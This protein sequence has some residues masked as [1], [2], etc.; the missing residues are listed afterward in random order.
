MTV[1]QPWLFDLRRMTAV[2][3]GNIEAVRNLTGGLTSDF[4]ANNAIELAADEEGQLIDLRQLGADHV[5]AGSL[6][7][8]NEAHLPFAAIEFLLIIAQHVPVD[9]PGLVEHTGDQRMVV[10]SAAGFD[11]FHDRKFLRIAHS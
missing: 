4:R 11:P 5:V 2:R 6:D 10:A 1:D 9:V 3:D 7:R 8:L